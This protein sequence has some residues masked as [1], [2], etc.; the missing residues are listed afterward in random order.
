MRRRRCASCSRRCASAVGVLGLS[1]RRTANTAGER[2]NED[3]AVPPIRTSSSSER[4]RA[5]SPVRAASPDA[6]PR[7]REED[8]AQN[9]EA[10]PGAHRSYPKSTPS[11]SGAPEPIMSSPNE[12]ASGTT[13][14]T[15]AM[16]ASRC[17]LSGRTSRGPR[18]KCPTSPRRKRRRRASTAMDLL[19]AKALGDTAVV[20]P[21]RATTRA[22]AKGVFALVDLRDGEVVMRDPRS[23]SC[24][25]LSSPR[26][27][28][29]TRA[30]SRPPRSTRA[31]RAGEYP[32][33]RDRSR[34][35][36]GCAVSNPRVAAVVPRRPSGRETPEK[37]GGGV[38]KQKPSDR[39]RSICP[40][41][42]E[43]LTRLPIPSLFSSAARSPARS[44]RSSIP[45][46]TRARSPL[47]R[48]AQA[49]A[50][51]RQEEGPGRTPKK[52]RSPRPR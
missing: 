7:R 25:R 11:P 33:Q 6:P 12:V 24:R 5:S 17:A 4:G 34:R 48:R 52:T 2:S 38:P 8:R 43:R 27:R 47:R 32:I 18:K 45:C 37:S 40:P 51:V 3:S 30:T 16:A 19:F 22:R 23:R 39:R 28:S 9:G 14:D 10:A 46:S 36:V 50:Q 35:G 1:R 26:L 21:A 31:P 20:Q 13:P 49:Q 42:T 41:R 44:R 29:R 15:A